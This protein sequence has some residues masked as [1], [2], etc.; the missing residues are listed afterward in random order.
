MRPRLDENRY[1]GTR[2]RGAVGGVRG[3]GGVGP[4]EAL[5]GADKVAGHF[6]VTQTTVYRWCK[7]GRV[8]CMKSEGYGA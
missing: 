1:H 2:E 6:W 8:P 7:E 3:G 5:L 4:G